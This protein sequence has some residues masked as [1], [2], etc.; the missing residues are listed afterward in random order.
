MIVESPERM[1]LSRPPESNVDLDKSSLHAVEEKLVIQEGA[2]TREFR[3][4]EG[5]LLRCPPIRLTR[6]Y[7]IKSPDI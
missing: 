3:I 4:S 1:H 6:G 7:S 5:A 2:V